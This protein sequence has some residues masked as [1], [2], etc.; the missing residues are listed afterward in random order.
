MK[1][2]ELTGCIKEGMK[3]KQLLE[4]FVEK[5]AEMQKKII[6]SPQICRD[7]KSLWKWLKEMGS[8]NSYILKMKP[9]LAERA[10]VSYTLPAE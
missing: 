9:L 8:L 5:V 3:R 2:V 1:T 10:K 6:D 4:D 7:L